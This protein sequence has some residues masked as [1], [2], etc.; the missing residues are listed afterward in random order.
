MSSLLRLAASGLILLA[1]SQA[2]AQVD[3]PAPPASAVQRLTVQRDTLWNLA[4]ALSSVYPG[5]SRAQIMVA[6]LRTNPDAFVRGNLHRLRTGASLKLPGV[7]QVQAES[8]AD[9]DALVASHLAKMRDPAVIPPLPPLGGGGVVVPAAP[10]ASVAPAA[11]AVVAE[12]APVLAAPAPE[13]A[14]VPAPEPA[15]GP[16]APPRVEVAGGPVVTEPVPVAPSAPSSSGL[17]WLP[18]GLGVLLLVGLTLLWRQRAALKAAGADETVEAPQASPA[19]APRTTVFSN[20]AADMA[21]LVETTAA[22]RQLV[23]AP[24]GRQI[25]PVAVMAIDSARLVTARDAQLQLQIARTWM[26]LGRAEAARRLLGDMLAAA[27]AATWTADVQALLAR[28]G[29]AAT[30]A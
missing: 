30:R 13:P 3:A 10:A 25:E 29:S 22:S 20:A 26:D 18:Y 6:V 19:K 9:A 15:P 17:S 11:P 28:L 16:V 24:A 21:R 27:P 14:V 8:R 7:A 1:G 5:Q 12:P 4:G 2:L 23:Q